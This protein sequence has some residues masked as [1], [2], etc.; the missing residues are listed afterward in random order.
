MKR[1]KSKSFIYGLLILVFMF[2][3]VPHSYAINGVWHTPYGVEDRYIAEAAERYPQDP[4]AGE[5]VFVKL[6]TWPIEPG[7]SVWIEWELNGVPQSAIGGSWKYNDSGTNN[8][9]WEVALGD[10][11]KGDHVEY[12]VK[13]DQYGSNQK[14]IG[15][16]EFT[17]TDWES[18][19]S[20]SSYTD[21]GTHLVLN[22]AANT[23]SFS[24][25]INLAFDS[26]DVFRVQMSP[27]GTGAFATG[28]DVFSV[29]DNTTFYTV[30]TAD[31]VIKIDK[32]PFKMNVYESDGTTLIAQHY[33][34][35]SNRNMSWLTDGTSIIDK[36]QDNFYTPSNEE[37]YGFGERYNNFGKRGDVVE[38]YIYNQ[39]LN[40]N[41]KTYLAIPYFLNTNGYGLLVNSTYY[42]KFEMASSPLPTDM[43]TFTV[44]TGGSST[45][46]LDYYF[47]SGDDL[48]EVI[49]NYA[50]S[51]SLPELLPKW[52]FGLWLSANE[53]DRESEIN[54]V[55]DNLDT[56]NIPATALVLEQWSDEHTFYVWNDATYTA[57]AGD[58]S[59]SS[60]D[61]TYG[62]R[63]P[64]PEGMIEDIHAA[65]L[66]VLLWQT[67]TMKYTG[68]AYEQ[69]DND[70]A[71]MIAQDYAV[72]DGHGGDYRIPEGW[73]GNSLVM[74]FTNPAAEDWWFEKRDYL[75][76]D[77]HIDGF[78]TDGGEVIWGRDTT[79]YN[80]KKGDEMRNQYPNEYI[81]AYYDYAKS[82]NA[83][84]A[85][86]SRSGTTGIQQYPAI[87][88]GDQESTF[89]TMQ[90]SLAAGLSANISG[91][92]Y[93]SWDLGGFTGTYPSAELYKRSVTMSA[94]TPVVQIHS[95][96]ANPSTSEERTPWNSVSRNSGDT[97]IMN[98]FQK[99]MNIRMN[100][101]PY[102]Y[103][104]ATKT[105]Q[106]GVPLMR[107]MAVEYPEDTNTHDLVYQYMFG[108][109]LLVAPIVEQSQYNKS[110]YLPEGEWIDFFY[111]AARPGGQTIS[112]YA[113]HDQIPVFVKSGAIIP[114][115]LNGDYELGGTIGND[116]D[117]YT[118]LA[119]RVYP[120]GNT[121]YAWNDD[122]GGGTVGAS[123]KTITSS[124]NYASNETTVVLPAMDTAST[125]QV[126]TT[127]PSAVTVNASGL[128]QYYSLSALAGSS[129]GWYF[130]S[131]NKFVHVKV[132][133]GTSSRTVELSGVH[134]A[135]YEAEYA[136]HYAVSTND[137]HTGYIGTGFVDGF[138]SIGDYIEFDVFVPSAGSYNVDVKYSSG[139]GTGSRTIYV[140]GS[141]AAT[142]SL[143]V[144][145]NWDTWGTSTAS[146]T[147][148]AGRNKIKV[149]YD[150]TDS[151]GI[152]VDHLTIR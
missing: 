148:V 44:D 1:K 27:N 54:T 72:K 20:V 139:G 55:L 103:S 50:E 58:E 17:V 101:L 111:G 12:T 150:G 37:F 38:T 64:D 82:K 45:S 107:S 128:T 105:S 85:S 63:W 43:Y 132:A 3:S 29:T 109:N 99:Y 94:F 95:E 145:A 68:Y 91:V 90:Q 51:T 80:G 131:L 77:L 2:M 21:N 146:L 136:A 88:A 151:L 76:D 36:V 141:S 4:K 71:Y 67:P 126:Y 70:E 52:G 42:S 152:N 78:K 41:E 65:G 93:W 121:S 22:A 18:I 6:N 149:Q 143:P 98:V 66:R 15:P 133:A 114:L 92:P 130:D 104:E 69:K 53:W 46:M 118:N 24:P 112:Y 129:Q 57:K 14:S 147:L 138:A 35:G 39:Y 19:A 113:G 33:N 96:K 60:S 7:Q 123:I 119:F 144:T 83:D 8:T 49:S 26:A 81:R 9:F 122:V 16:F 23:G 86:F 59:F 97:S 25:K 134:K 135:S 115:N 56:Y 127:K 106:T 79:F 84:A 89:G 100:L 34:P 74:D 75:L 62:G 120:D 28:V 110:I 48:K 140:N 102:I 40:Q 13:A 87:W 30:T 116:L 117:S 125:V 31:L 10:F 142:M 61:F 124:E 47:Y 5:D 73:F 137:N 32:N 108:D 11:N